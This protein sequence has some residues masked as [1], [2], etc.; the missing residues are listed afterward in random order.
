[1]IVISDPVSTNTFSSFLCEYKKKK[2]K[3]KSS[4]VHAFVSLSDHDK[5][6]G[7]LNLCPSSFILIFFSE[8]SESPCWSS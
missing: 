3:K 1:M 4:V 5:V 2:K 7:I 6:T 8:G